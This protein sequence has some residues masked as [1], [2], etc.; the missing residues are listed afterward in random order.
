MCGIAGILSKDY[1]QIDMHRLSVMTDAI[2]HRGPDGVGYWKNPEETVAFGHRRLAV[3]DLSSSAAQPFVFSSRYTLVFNGEIYNYREIKKTLQEKGYS[4]KTSSDTE[5]LAA[6]YDC[7]QT[8]CLQQLDGM[9]AFAIWDEVNQEL[10]LARDRFGEKPLFYSYKD[11]TF[12]FASECKAIWAAGIPRS[13][14]HLMLLG[15]LAN[16][17][18]QNALDA[19]ITFY[20]DIEQIPPG[21]YGIFRLQEQH[22]SVNMYWDLDKQL[23]VKIT[24]EEA[25][26]QFLHL[27]KQSIT[28]RLRSDV[29]VGT[30][31]SGG[32]D[33]SSIVAMIDAIVRDSASHFSRHAFTAI[34]PG[35][36][37]NEKLFAETVSTHFCLHQHTVEPSLD[38]FMH[39]WDKL[40]YHQ[41]QPFGSASVYAQF[42]V[43]ELAAREG[44]TVLVDGQ[45]ADETLAGYN[46]Y[47]HWYLQEQV[48][49]FRY[50]F[51]MQERIRLQQNKI[52][53][54]WGFPNYMAALLPVVANAA[55]EERERKKILMHPHLE[56]DYVHAHYDKYYSVY[57]PPVSKLNDILYFNAM[58]QGLGELLHYADRNSM[59]FGRELRLP[60]LSH[61][62]VEFVFSLP[63]HFKIHYGFT[64][65]LLR[66]AMKSSLPES[67]VW[68]TD[69]VGYEPPQKKW[70]E[71]PA[72]RERIHEARTRLIS[73]GILHKKVLDQPIKALGAYEADNYDWRYMCGA[74]S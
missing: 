43:M 41:E 7:W 44:V 32:L 71:H 56:A 61:E 73:D 59:A 46:K 60:F 63:S 1:H 2:K 6:A 20:K 17:H 22:F 4:F 8:E 53:F 36:E 19:S 3:I 74:M 37:K 18:T 47:I 34:F 62:L 57:K 40:C 48:A 30:S 70:M 12:L 67:I 54:H 38:G 65:W 11:G 27:F 45:G 14:N 55:M 25:T 42:K 16:G 39:D 21:H 50:G 68:R 66:N 31:L 13:W 49:K 35:Y 72:L 26:E 29:A 15:Y 64:K 28:R 33:S 9:F 51:A 10:F 69:K 5:V 58:Q 23:T 52:P 24:E